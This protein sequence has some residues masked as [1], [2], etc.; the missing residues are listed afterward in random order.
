MHIDP[1]IYELGGIKIWWYGLAYAFGFFAVHLWILLRRERLGLTREEALEFSL[2]LAAGALICGRVFDV[3]VY[4]WDFYRQNVWQLPCFWHGGLA[5]HGFVIGGML[6]GIVFCRMRS[7]SFAPLADEVVIPGAFLLAL[8]RIGNHINGEVYGSLSEAAWAMQF[9]Y[10]SGFRHP[11]AL[12]EGGKNVLVALILL[13][14][15][16]YG[17]R[18]PGLLFMHF[19]FWYGLMRLATDHFRD[20]D[21][22]WF[23][24]GRGQYFNLVM[25]IVG[26]CG[27]VLILKAARVGGLRHLEE[28]RH[29]PRPSEW[30]WLKTAVF[31]GLVA[32]CLTIPSGWTQQVLETMRVMQ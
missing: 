1:L 16:R 7:R 19:V 27:I 3:V 11:V 4:E 10:A 6:G 29:P 5:T 24:I 20:Y 12:Y 28:A 23:G 2:L 17:R 13:V 14:V 21:S 25:A 9:P 31:Y 26:A 15:L 30:L 22:Y 32:F 18:V 8:G